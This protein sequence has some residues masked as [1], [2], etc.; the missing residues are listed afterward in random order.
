M[1]P[2]IT[3]IKVYGYHLDIFGHV[4]NARYL[5]FM[6]A[7]RWNFVEG[8]IDLSEWKR[9]GIAFNVVNININYRRP[10]VL[11]DLLEIHTKMSDIA[12]KS[13]A[14]RQEIFIKGTDTL[15]VDADVTFVMVDIKKK[16]AIIFPDDLRDLFLSMIE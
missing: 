1:Q 10:A 4:N 7:G 9:R 13:A 3:D 11:G 8:K 15:I 2:S 16:K 6:E 5:E 14:I 12:E